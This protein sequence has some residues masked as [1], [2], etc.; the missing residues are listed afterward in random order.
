M[1]DGVSYLAK[2][3][4]NCW[5]EVVGSQR[6]I[7]SQL[8]YQC[9]KS[10]SM[11]MCIPKMYMDNFS[12]AHVFASASFSVWAYQLWVSIIDRDVNVTSFQVE[13]SF[14]CINTTLFPY[15]QRHLLMILDYKGSGQK[16][17]LAHL[18]WWKLDLGLGQEPCWLFAEQLAEGIWSA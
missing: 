4:R 15:L 18:C 10:V 9:L 5:L 7:C 2:H 3:S 12:P 11:R 14:F 1:C 8:R 13:D 17:W 6:I 16:V